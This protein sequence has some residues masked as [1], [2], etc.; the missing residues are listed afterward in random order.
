MCEEE[1][2]TKP[3]ISKKVILSLSTYGKEKEAKHQLGNYFR[4]SAGQIRSIKSFRRKKS[5]LRF[6]SYRLTDY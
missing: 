5:H 4:L 3:N 6:I 1:E 2:E